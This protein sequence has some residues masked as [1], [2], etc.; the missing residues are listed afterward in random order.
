M[1]KSI[2][3]SVAFLFALCVVASS[4]SSPSMRLC[5]VHLNDMLSKLCSATGY[6]RIIHKR[7]SPLM[8]MDPLDPIQYIEEKEASSAELLPYRLS[9]GRL[10]NIFQDNGLS[11]L[12]STRRRTRAGIVDECCRRSCQLEELTN[13]CAA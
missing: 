8:D 9:N 2:S 1:C 12:T 3:L 10:R 13:Y 4:S 7:G 6:N 11:S 5:S